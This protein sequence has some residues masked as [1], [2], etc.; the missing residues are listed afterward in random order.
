MLA[1]VILP[2][3]AFAAAPDV[4]PQLPTNGIVINDAA[5]IAAQANSAACGTFKDNLWKDSNHAFKAMW[6]A[7]VVVLNTPNPIPVTPACYIVPGSWNDG[8]ANNPTGD[9]P[10]SRPAGS[11]A[12]ENQIKNSSLGISAATF[13]QYETQDNNERNNA[14]PASRIVGW[15]LEGIL[16]VVAAV[17][18]QV[19]AL[20]GTIFDNTVYPIL[21]I[22]EMPNVVNIGWAIIR[23]VC[24]MFFI[25]I[26]IV[27]GLAAILRIEKYDY[28]HLLG[29]VILMALLVNFSKVIAVTIMNFVNLI[30][31]M[32]WNGI[33]LFQIYTTL[34]RIA[35][36]VNDLGTATASGWMG[37]LAAGIGKILYM[38]V[39]CGAFL[40]LAGM[41]V[42]RLVGLYVLIIFSPIA[43]VADILPATKDYAHAWWHQFVH[44]LIWA[45][46]ALFMLRL[47]IVVVNSSSQFSVLGG[48]TNDSAFTFFILAAFLLAAVLVAEHAGMVGGNMIVNGVEGLMHKGFEAGDMW[49]ARGANRK[50]DSTTAKTRRA[51]SYLSVGSW[52]KG[53]QQ[54]FQ[55]KEHESYLV[56]AAQRHD[57]FNKLIGGHST[58]YGLKAEQQLV[59]DEKKLI[60]T[61][62]NTELI[63]GMQG[64]I[65]AKEGEKAFA[66]AQ[67]LFENYDGNEALS[68][69]GYGTDHAG[70]Q[71]FIEKEFVPLMG[72]EKAYRLAYDLS[73][74]AEEANHWNY[75][76]AFTGV[77]GR[78]GKVRYEKNTD[79]GSE[80]LA[81]IAK[82]NPQQAARTL[83]RL[84]RGFIEVDIPELDAEGKAKTDEH[85]NVMTTRVNLG[86]DEWGKKNRQTIDAKN[87]G[88][89]QNTGNMNTSYNYMLNDSTGTLKDNKLLWLNLGN[90]FARMTPEQRAQ[91][92]KLISNAGVRAVRDAEGKIVR[93][94][95]SGK[96][97]VEKESADE[98]KARVFTIQ[99][100]YGF[101][102][103]GSIKVSDLK[104]F[105]DLR[106][107][108][109]N[110]A[111]EDGRDLKLAKELKDLG[112]K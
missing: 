64:A 110:H 88:D 89:F 5:Y 65:H 45:P 70:F 90:R 46:V 105:K 35:N 37:A 111:E 29:E 54:R 91:A 75:A 26:L 9:N 76:R 55:T 87:A 23:D 10:N 100:A 3:F 24:N 108:L 95:T 98:T 92:Q 84:G 12:L 21:H 93:D 11:T 32:F 71:E 30:A 56:A 50:G 73:R 31:A 4:G 69:M 58:D 82:M 97:V 85:G 15:I 80:V 94:K 112:D 36:P 74:T 102:K 60:H 14:G 1:T 66:Y 28:R 106:N 109:I 34:M 13:T 86:L 48:N 68:R 61:K 67:S 44:Y 27:I 42:I 39:A 63:A 22:T 81:E 104:E 18:A 7:G 59:A 53:W 25:L 49:L 101:L 41:F 57:T 99:Q 77:M 103:D 96:V 79:A 47:G 72:K 52:Q 33:G 62:G 17:L 43:Y 16:G 2:N 8:N 107:E 51:L 38:I 40:I 6:W 20:A 83:N 19:T 78:D